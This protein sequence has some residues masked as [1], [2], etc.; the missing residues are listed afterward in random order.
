VRSFFNFYSCVSVAGDDVFDPLLPYSHVKP[1]EDYSAGSVFVPVCLWF[2]D[3]VSCLVD[4]NNL[5]LRV[6]WVNLRES[7]NVLS[8]A[9]RRVK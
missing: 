1:A 8:G 2:L 9:E 7:G 6:D 3:F 5:M 4:T